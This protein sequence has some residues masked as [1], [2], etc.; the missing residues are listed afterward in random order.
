MF[1]ST[2]YAQTAAP[3][4]GGADM[5]VQFL[6]LILIFVVFYFLLIRPQQKKMKEHKGML[7]AIR[8][9]DRVVTGG[10]IIGTVTKVGPEDELQVEIAENVRVRVMRSTVNLV[11][12]KSE[13]AKSADEKAEEKV[14]DRK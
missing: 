4:A 14:A 3:A 2:A 10:G 12:S 8:R 6:P 11:L 1:V 7:E 9:G 13:P 5:I